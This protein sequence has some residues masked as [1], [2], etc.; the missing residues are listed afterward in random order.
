VNEDEEDEWEDIGT[1]EEVEDDRAIRYNDDSL[2]DPTS[3]DDN[4]DC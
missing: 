2:D 3:E 4:D 1:D